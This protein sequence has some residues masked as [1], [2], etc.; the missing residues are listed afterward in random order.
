MLEKVRALEAACSRERPARSARSLVLHGRDS[1]LGG[2][3]D[4]CRVLL[5]ASPP[6]KGG[7]GDVGGCLGHLKTGVH[8]LEL[9][10]GEV[11]KL[12]HGHSPSKVLVVVLLNAGKVLG[13]DSEALDVLDGVLEAV[14]VTVLGPPGVEHRFDILLGLAKLGVGTAENGE[15]NGREKSELHC[16]LFVVVVVVVVWIVLL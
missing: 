5:L 13:E 4:G 15:R 14:Q 7:A 2:P 16:C 10:G 12:V 3:V 1:A 8:L 11:A 6:D 9:G